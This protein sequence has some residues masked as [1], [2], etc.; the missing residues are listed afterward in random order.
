MQPFRE[1]I[2]PNQK[3]YWDDTLDTLFESSKSVLIDLVKDGV[4]SY[5][6]S[7]TTCIQPDWSKDGVGYLLL[8][9]H[10]QCAIVSPFCCENGWKLIHAGS[11]FTN[12]AESNYAATEGEDTSWRFSII[13][14]PGKWTKGPDALSRYPTTIAAALRDIRE[15]ASDY[16]VMQCSDVED[17]PY[18]ASTCALQ[19][20]GSVT[21]DHIVSA[22]RSDDEYQTLLKL[23]SCSFPGKR[24]LVEPTCMHKYWEVRHRL[25]TFQGVALLDQRLIIPAKLRNVVLS[26]LHSANQ[27][28]TGMKFRAYQ[29]VYWPGMDR[30]IQIH[31]ETCQ[32]CIRHAPSHH[33]EPLV[34][35]PSPSYPFQQVC[36]DYF[37][38]EGHSYL[39]VVDRFSGW[40][41]NYAFKAHEVNHWTLQHI[42]R[43]LFI[44][45]GVSE[46]LSTDGGPQFT[47]E[48]FQQFLKLWGV[49]HRLSSASYPQSNGRAE[50]A[51]K[52]AKRIIHNNRSSDGGLNTDTAARAIL[53][54][55]NTPLPDIELSPAQILLHR[56]LRDS[57]PAHPDHYQPHKEWVLTAEEREKALSKR[58]HILVKNHDATARK[59]RPLV[60]G[61]NVVAQGENQE[62]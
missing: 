9:K 39:A 49:N 40:L 27:G 35:T 29:C 38:I 4:Q 62:T 5:D 34:L 44:A 55:R 12:P 1:L 54:Y 15:Q 6:I 8:Q 18:I 58:N 41:C 10:C 43:N 30:S 23:I 42:F 26:T 16:D 22:A 19:Q 53:Q 46:E 61:T 7:R 14:C 31:R 37:Q 11:R 3:F 36:A 45:Y 48:A 59:L 20:I 51:V 2:K 33:A 17:A 52:A 56:Q 57:I 28:T 24:N 32:D 47:A 60:L 50:V 25:S 21:F 13:H